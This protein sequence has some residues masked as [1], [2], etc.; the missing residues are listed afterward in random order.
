MEGRG[1]MICLLLITSNWDCCGFHGGADTWSGHWHW[2]GFRQPWTMPSMLE[3]SVGAASCVSPYLCTWELL[4]SIVWKVCI[5]E[6]YLP[7][8]WIQLCIQSGKWYSNQSSS[9]DADRTLFPALER[10]GVGIAPL[11]QELMLCPLWKKKVSIYR[12][13]N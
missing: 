6:L 8:V 4:L 12:A 11:E 3:D 2:I 7:W 5:G 10:W 1:N 13:P 9:D